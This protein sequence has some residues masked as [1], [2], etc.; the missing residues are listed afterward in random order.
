MSATATNELD[1]VLLKVRAVLGANGRLEI[2]Q[3]DPRIAG[4]FG[5][6]G[7]AKVRLHLSRNDICVNMPP[8]GGTAVTVYRIGFNAAKAATAPTPAPTPA[9]KAAPAAPTTAPK[10]VEPTPAPTPEPPKVVKNEP[11]APT[12][13]PTPKRYQHSYRP[14]VFLK[15][16][17]DILADEATHNVWF[18]GPTG[19]GKT[20]AVAHIARQLGYVAFR[21]NCDPAMGPENFLGEKTIDIDQ[22]TAQNFVKFAEGVVVKAMTCGLD[23]H[24][25]EVG[26]PGLLYLDEA[27]AMPQA[28]S[29]LLNPLLE[30]DEP[31]RTIILNQDGGRI[32]RSHSKF[33]IIIAGN[34]AGRGCN[35]LSEQFYTAQTSALDLSLLKR[36]TAIFNFGYDREVEKGILMEK[37]GNDKVVG[38][39]IRFRDE[40]RK[41][42][43]AGKLQTPFSTRDLVHIADL[44]RIFRD[45]P[46]AIWLACGE[47][48]LDAEKAIYNEQLVSLFGKDMARAMT[49]SGVDYM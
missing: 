29:I 30:T 4:I 14:P 21:L 24:G 3:T 25:N 36:V 5:E 41:H 7:K 23:E 10:A 22:K 38:E 8:P 13:K 33:R 35:S 26:A 6:L 2:D 16:V 19:C 49:Q 11:V 20:V 18:K 39:I 17:V 15:D 34:T 42:L 31:R 44:W 37:I 1:A 27:P 46:K 32:V 28:L 48:V 45:I 43:K 40:I 12:S 47:G 9:A